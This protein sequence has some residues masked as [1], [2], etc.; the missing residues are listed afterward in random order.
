MV[1]NYIITKHLLIYY[2][3]HYFNG[4]TSTE[5]RT[6]FNKSALLELLVNH[7]L[8]M[9]HHSFY[10]VLLS[11]A[12]DHKCRALIF[13]HNSRQGKLVNHY[14]VTRPLIIYNIHVKMWERLLKGI[15]LP[16]V[17]TSL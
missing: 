7:Y 4:G 1:N 10:Q 17:V 15:K 11:I 2:F 14:P 9:R 6:H 5:I 13:Y 8:M 3:G 16:T 12:Q